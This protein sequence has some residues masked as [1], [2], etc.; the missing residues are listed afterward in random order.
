MPHCSFDS[1]S[2]FHIARIE[3]VD[4]DTCTCAYLC[5]LLSGVCFF[6]HLWICVKVRMFAVCLVMFVVICVSYTRLL[7]RKKRM[8][9][10]IALLSAVGT[11]PPAV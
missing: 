9:Q 5:S 6:V 7:V 10:K 1:P 11:L 8:K 3:A 4:G 2:G